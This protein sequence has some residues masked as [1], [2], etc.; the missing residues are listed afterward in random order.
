MRK[1]GYPLLAESCFQRYQLSSTSKPLHI[2]ESMPEKALLQGE[3]KVPVVECH[4]QIR[5][6]KC[7]GDK[8]RCPFTCYTWLQ[9]STQFF[10][11]SLTILKIVIIHRWTYLQSRNKGADVA[12]KHTIPRGEGGGGMNWETLI[13]KCTLACIKQ[14][15]NE[16]LPYSAGNSTQCL[17][18]T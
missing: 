16:S 10:F 11:K 1:L 13:G 18:V 2:Q 3:R 12:N 6:G 7:Q 8:C 5:V 4:H 17:V 9:V 15:T 14:I